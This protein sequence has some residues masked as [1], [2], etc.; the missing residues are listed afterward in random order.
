MTPWGSWRG[1]GPHLGPQRALLPLR[2]NDQAGGW[3]GVC[4]I[5]LRFLIT[6]RMFW[7]S[8]RA[9]ANPPYSQASSTQFL[10]GAPHLPQGECGD[11][12]AL[13]PGHQRGQ[14]EAVNSTFPK[15]P[16]FGF[17]QFLPVTTPRK[18]KLAL[19]RQLLC[20]SPKQGP[21]SKASCLISATALCDCTHMPICLQGPRGSE[22]PA[23]CK[24]PGRQGPGSRPQLRSF[25][26]ETRRTARSP[27]LRT[28]H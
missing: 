1:R 19:P 9:L 16:G 12:L 11:L 25:P 8:G 2:N 13:S 24:L 22:R 14:G 20:A 5:Q 28:F 21:L 17:Q 18:K 6:D 26:R 10:T 7:S 27:Y 3:E 23:G 4:G 15:L